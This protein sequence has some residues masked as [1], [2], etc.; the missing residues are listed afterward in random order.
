MRAIL[1]VVIN[2]V[3]IWAAAKLVPGVDYY[4]TVWMLLLAGLV[5]GVINLLVKPIVTLLSLPLILLT[6]G[7]FYLVVN[8]VMLQLAAMLV[9][10]FSIS[11]CLPAV[12]GAL[13]F[14]VVNWVL[15]GLLAESDDD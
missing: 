12:L 13:V 11:G 10:G 7:L 1:Q 2:A 4:G 6:L 8:G 5:M 9:P 3:A 15:G 14:S